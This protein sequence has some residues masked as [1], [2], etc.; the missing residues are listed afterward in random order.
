MQNW[1]TQL[2][3]ICQ[4]QGFVYGSDHGVGRRSSA[5][6]LCQFQLNTLM[7]PTAITDIAA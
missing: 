1:R 5:C 3:P 2:A 6:A 7:A 4:P